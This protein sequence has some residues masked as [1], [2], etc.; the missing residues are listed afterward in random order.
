MV[1]VEGLGG[2]CGEGED[3]WSLEPVGKGVPVPTRTIRCTP[4]TSCHRTRNLWIP[5][6][7]GRS[8]GQCSELVWKTFSFFEKVMKLSFE[9]VIM[10]W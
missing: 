6:L 5:D 3:A 4:T 2:G 7:P 9:K 8:V 1:V 10:N